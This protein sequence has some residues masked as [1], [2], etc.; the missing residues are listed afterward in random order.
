MRDA[1]HDGRDPFIILREHYAG[2]RKPRVITL[3]NQLTTLKKSNS[4]TM[5]EY[6]LRGETA[7]N[8]LRTAE[9][10]V[11]DALLVAM[12]SKGLPDDYTAFVAVVTQSDTVQNFP[13]FKQGLRNFEKIEKTR[14]IK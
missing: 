13:K 7:A 2:S 9:E 11:S 8:A 14:R 12:V 6:I 1:R 3:Y 4:E 5:T 10:Y